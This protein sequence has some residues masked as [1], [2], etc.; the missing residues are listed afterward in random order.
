MRKQ[1]EG[2]AVDTFVTALYT[3]AEYCDYGALRDQMIRDRIVVGISNATLS[4][5]L[6]LDPDLTLDKAITQVHQSESVKQQQ[7][8]LRGEAGN[9]PIGAQQ[10]LSQQGKTWQRKLN[11]QLQLGNK[12]CFRCGRTPSHDRE[13]CP[14]KDAICRKCSKRGHYQAMC[15]TA[16]RVG[17]IQ[18]QEDDIFLGAVETQDGKPW[19]VSLLLNK[20]P[21][22]FHIDTGA[23]VTVISG[24]IWKQIGKPTLQASKRTLRGPDSHVLPVKGLLISQ[25]K[26][27]QPVIQQEIYV[28]EGLHKPL[29]GRPAIE[30]LGLIACVQGV[31]DETQGWK[32]QF[33]QLFEG[34]G[35][36]EGDYKIELEPG[37]KPYALSTPR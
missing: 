17:G 21:V 31:Q 37:A 3:L 28:I 18:T 34:L 27:N 9:T 10:Q 16:V 11:P 8:L 19:S 33:P 20:T 7:P 14:A 2:E 12:S 25:L 29:L 13:H 36:L 5:K 1:E 24:A 4:E 15:R 6:Q 30:A 22:D 32:Q 35:K 23:E 26:N